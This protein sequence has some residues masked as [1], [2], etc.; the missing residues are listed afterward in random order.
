MWTSFAKYIGLAIS[1][2]ITMILAR[3]LTPNE[4][5]VVAVATVIITFLTLF[6]QMGIGPAVI[7]FDDLNSKDLDDIFTLTIYLGI[8]LSLLLFVGAWPISSFYNEDQL[9]GVCQILSI[10]VFFCAINM[11]PNALMLK[12]KRFKENAIRNLLLQVLTGTLA[13]I[14]A[15]SG[16]GLYS[17]LIMPVLTS[18]GIFI[19]NSYFYPMHFQKS[20]SLI[21]IK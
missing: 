14:A 10:N 7:Q 17:L 11:V 15:I 8:F 13:V 1:F 6:C 5:G 19:F 3:I 9:K 18:V 20:P 12:N 4:F 16:F 21:P 2:A